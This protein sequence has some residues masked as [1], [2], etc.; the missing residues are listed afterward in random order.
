MGH[1]Y[2]PGKFLRKKGSLYRVDHDGSL[3]RL[4][5]D[6][7]ISNGLCWD[8]REHAFY[9]ADSFEYAIRRYHYD[10]STGDICEYHLPLG[11]IRD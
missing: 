3:H 4:V 10:D 7:D 9:Y 8:K 11:R 1:E 5:T 6:V 2:E